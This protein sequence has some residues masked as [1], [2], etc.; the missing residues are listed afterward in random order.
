MKR[1]ARLFLLLVVVASVPVHATT[2][3]WYQLMAYCFARC[4]AQAICSGPAV[5][6]DACDQCY[7]NCQFENCFE[8]N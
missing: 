3:C 2:Y 6:E 7:E 1:L 5:S 8:A 4:D